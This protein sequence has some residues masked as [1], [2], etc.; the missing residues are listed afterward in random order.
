MWMAGSESS[1]AESGAMG[2]IMVNRVGGKQN[3]RLVG[4]AQYDQKEEFTWNQPT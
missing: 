2:E 3:T 4:R 1:E